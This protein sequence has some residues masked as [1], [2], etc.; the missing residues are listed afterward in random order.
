MIAVRLMGGLGN[1]MF[2]YAAGRRLAD[3]LGVRL[4]LDL[5]RL[6]NQPAGETPR[7]FQ[8]DC[9]RIR[10]DLSESKIE[11][12]RLR[13]RWLR[14]SKRP[15]LVIERGYPINRRVLRARDGTLLVG[16]W[17]SEKYFADDADAIRRDFTLQ[18]PLSPYKQALADQ[19]DDRTV[20]VQIRRTDY[21]T[22]ATTAKMI[23]ALPLSYYERAAAEIAEIVTSPR[24]LVISDDPRWCEEN[25]DLGHPTTIVERTPAG[26]H[27]DMILLSMCRHFVIANSSFGWWGAWLSESP[28]KRV[29]APRRW[30]ADASIDAR[31]LV[32]EGWI[33]L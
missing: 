30:F 7:E 1:Q 14:R 23:G 4:V 13:P 28:E 16:Y 20:A 25:L 3:A 29:I 15:L 33:R 18:E 11:T 5:S 6:R 21:I 9:F 10:A 22:H 19:V 31:D 27:E 17:Q 32:P 8:L 24:F 26:D 12:S 2:Q